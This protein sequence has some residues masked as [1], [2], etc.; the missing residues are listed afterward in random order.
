[1]SDYLDMLAKN[2]GELAEHQ[3]RIE[4][5]IEQALPRYGYVSFLANEVDVAPA[6]PAPF[7]PGH[8]KPVPPGDW[9]SV[10][11][12]ASYNLSGNIPHF[13]MLD[14]QTFQPINATSPVIF[15]LF[16]SYKQCG[17]A[18]ASPSTNQ[19]MFTLAFTNRELYVRT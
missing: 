4:R 3:A 1:M 2:M 18:V 11:V 6:P 12:I 7:V 5:A 19:G 8:M 15:P 10:M 16:G 14:D 9:R 17:L 13:L